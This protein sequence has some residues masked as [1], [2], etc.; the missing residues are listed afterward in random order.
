[1]TEGTRFRRSDL[2]RDVDR[3]DDARSFV[4]Y[5]DRA[6]VNLRE[7][8]LEVI[9]LLQ[10]PAG[11]SLLDV[12]SGAGE[13][14]I[15]VAGSVEAV[16]AVGIDASELMINTASSR[17]RSAGVDVHFALGDAQR[18]EFPDRSFDRVNCSRVLVHLEHPAMAVSEMARVLAPGGRLAI[19][20]PDHDA[21]M[22]DS[23]D[24]G[25]ARGVRHQLVTAL[26]SPD[27]GRRLRRLVLDAG[28]KVEDVS[29][30]VHSIDFVLDQ[31]RIFE[32]LDNAVKDGEIDSEAAMRW[33]T[34]IEAADASGRLF[35]RA[36]LYRAIATKAR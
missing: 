32:H 2:W 31:F 25:V 16:R 30:I 15:E 7:A 27:V 20:E 13:F 34:W 9:R 6:A 8:R 3:A 33:R 24:L 26:R 36:V 21:F 11:S 22:I 35:I 17:A 12:G 28:L 1:V 4:D 29:G 18:L 23:D 14:L 10:I 19:V 5:L